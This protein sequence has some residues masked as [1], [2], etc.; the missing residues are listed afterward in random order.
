MYPNEG[1]G[2]LQCLILQDDATFGFRYAFGVCKESCKQPELPICEPNRA[3][4]FCYF[5]MDDNQNPT[6]RTGVV[7]RLGYPSRK[8]VF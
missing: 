5:G 8:F 3:P 7:S 1:I 4:K 6:I 2:F